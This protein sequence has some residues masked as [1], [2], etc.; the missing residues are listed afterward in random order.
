MITTA[1]PEFLRVSPRP[2]DRDRGQTASEPSEEPI[3]ADLANPPAE[4][5][6]V[7]SL[8]R[9]GDGAETFEQLM[10]NPAGDAPAKTWADP[11]PNWAAGD[12]TAQARAAT[13]P[14]ILAATTPGRADEKAVPPTA[15][16]QNPAAGQMGAP[17]LGAADEL[18]SIAD[19]PAPPSPDGRAI[20]TARAAEA[21]IP[22]I[23]PSATSQDLKIPRSDAEWRDG[24]AAA[25]RSGI[26]RP[27]AP[28]T[29]LK[30]P[31]AEHASLVRAESASA[32]AMIATA[33]I[34]TGAEFEFAPE[35]AP[36]VQASA[37][38]DEAALARLTPT[39]VPAAQR[40]AAMATNVA[41]QIAAAISQGDGGVI[42]INLDPPELGRVTV[43]LTSTETGLAAALLTERPEIADLMRRHAEL[44]LRDL[45][46]AGYADVS[47]SFGSTSSEERRSDQSGQSADAPLD[48]TAENLAAAI[49]P[50]H[51]LAGRSDSGLDIRL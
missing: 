10:E 48:R 37:D 23:G 49:S 28:E 32:S 42:E 34:L 20:A 17:A 21:A 14:L 13:T 50:S 35:I 27:A 8:A 3:T 19:S 38:L 1:Q 39:G 22:A 11:G 43:K 7:L 18:S 25:R 31:S 15:R 2:T 6:A 46:N 12:A 9:G 40:T 45:K 36:L 4:H 41:S 26:D 5:R 30:P 33:S 16:P 51:G 47:L 24:W 44:L 29:P